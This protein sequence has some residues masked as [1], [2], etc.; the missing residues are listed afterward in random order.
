M[1]ELLIRLKP[2]IVETTF[3]EVLN[4]FDVMVSGFFYFFYLKSIIVGVIAIDEPQLLRK[5]WVL[6]KKV[7]DRK[8]R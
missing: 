7:V 1:D 2:K 4:G 8:L 6:Y 5:I 3:D